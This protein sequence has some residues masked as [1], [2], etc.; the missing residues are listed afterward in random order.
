MDKEQPP[1]EFT[2]HPATRTAIEKAFAEA[3]KNCACPACGENFTDSSV[4]WGHAW[5]EG[6]VDRIREE[7]RDIRDGPFKI[8]CEMCGRRSMYGI[9]AQSVTLVPEAPN[10]TT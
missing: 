3:V 5:R 9:F 6:Y 8:R 2:N 10:K 7:G 1:V 4:A